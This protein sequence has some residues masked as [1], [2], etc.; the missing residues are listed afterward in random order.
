[1]SV[2]GLWISKYDL[3]LSNLDNYKQCNVRYLWMCGTIL[4]RRLSVRAVYGAWGVLRVLQV[5]GVR[6]L[7]RVRMVRMG[8]MTVRESRR[9]RRVPRAQVRCAAMVLSE[10]QR[11]AR[12]PPIATLLHVRPRGASRRAA[13]RAAPCTRQRMPAR[14]MRAPVVALAARHPFRSTLPLPLASPLSGQP[15][16]AHPLIRTK[17]PE[18]FQL[19]HK[20]T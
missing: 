18:R 8:G 9:L 17:K 15:P 5:V 13:A 16:A 4:R 20:F 19:L 2:Y 11:R 3:W 10:R 14:L 7:V 12:W 1:M 6:V